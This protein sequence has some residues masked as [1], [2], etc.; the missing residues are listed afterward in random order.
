MDSFAKLRHR[1]SILFKNSK[2]ESRFKLKH[3]IYLTMKVKDH[4]KKQNA[5]HEIE[6]NPKWAHLQNVDTKH[7]LHPKQIKW[8]QNSHCT[9]IHKEGNFFDG[10]FI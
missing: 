1:T 7:L 10:E 6:I 4:S 9:I 5:Y 8:S 2:V 3:A